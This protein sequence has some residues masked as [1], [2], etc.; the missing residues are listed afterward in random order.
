MKARMSKCELG[1]DELSQA[2]NDQGTTRIRI[3]IFC[4]VLY[5]RSRTPDA[6]IST[7]RPDGSN[8]RPRMISICNDD[9]LS[10]SVTA[11]SFLGAKFEKTPGGIIEPSEVIE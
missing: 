9:A 1:I 10:E 2:V 8:R 6:V 5:G 7:W 4:T 3:Q 11:E